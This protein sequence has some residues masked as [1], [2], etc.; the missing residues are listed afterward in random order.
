MKIGVVVTDSCPSYVV[1]PMRLEK[2]VLRMYYVILSVIFGWY[3]LYLL[4]ILYSGSSEVSVMLRL[5]ID[6]TA[7]KLCY[8]GY[9][10]R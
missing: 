6:V 5:G 4:I 8:I 10:N 9:Y 7:I 3:W 2:M 1:D